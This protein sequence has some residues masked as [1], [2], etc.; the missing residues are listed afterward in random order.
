V[1]AVSP[2]ASSPLNAI[3]PAPLAAPATA[4]Q[5]WSALLAG[6]TAPGTNPLG[7]TRS[8]CADLPVWRTSS[9]GAPVA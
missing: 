4:A 6:K 1:T 5:S 7:P 9:P 8:S 2:L 3:T